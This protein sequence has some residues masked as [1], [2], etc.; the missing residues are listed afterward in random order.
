MR[1]FQNNVNVGMV[2]N[3]KESIAGFFGCK[4]I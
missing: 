4:G 1:E 2:H 3:L